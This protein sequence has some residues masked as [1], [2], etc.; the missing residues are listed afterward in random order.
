MMI[1]DEVNQLMMMVMIELYNNLLLLS[2]LDHYQNRQCPLMLNSME[3]VVNQHKQVYE[4]QK[5]IVVVVVHLNRVGV[6]DDED[7]VDDDVGDDVEFEENEV[8]IDMFHAVLMKV[9]SEHHYLE[10]EE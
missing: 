5:Q 6:K 7:A 1:V 4:E 10:E 8:L 9:K 2:M 3:M